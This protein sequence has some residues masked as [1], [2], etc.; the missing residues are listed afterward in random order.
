MEDLTLNLENKYLTEEK[1]KEIQ[2]CFRMF[3]KDKDNYVRFNE[4]RNIIKSLSIEI[5]DEDILEIIKEVKDLRTNKLGEPVI[6]YEQYEYIV[7]QLL[8]EEDMSQELAD[9]FMNF[10][11]VGSDFISC[12]KFVHYMKTLGDKLSDEEIDEMIK[13]FDK[14]STGRITVESF[15]RVLCSK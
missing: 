15:V 4:L 1:M 7:L 2:E 10:T 9:A 11:N 3:D 5:S 13:D 6:S 8:K 14:D 12:D